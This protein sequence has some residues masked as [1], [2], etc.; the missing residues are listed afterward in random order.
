MFNNANVVNHTEHPANSR[1]VMC[2]I[3]TNM[4]FNSSIYVYAY[5]CVD[6]AYC[7]RC[8]LELVLV[9]PMRAVTASLNF[10]CEA[11]YFPV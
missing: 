2:A 9:M 7:R 11:N 5:P 1:T 3:N 4:L 10:R 6:A 8:T